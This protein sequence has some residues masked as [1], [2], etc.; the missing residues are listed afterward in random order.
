MTGGGGA[1]INAN[2]NTGP[3]SDI[4]L[5]DNLIKGNTA[6][7]DAA[8]LYITVYTASSIPGAEITLTRNEIA[9]NT[10]YRD[11]GGVYI[12]RSSSVNAIGDVTLNE[13]VI[14][15]N[16]CNDVGGGVYM[17]SYTNGSANLGTVNL[18]ENIVTGNSSYEMAGESI[19]IL[20]V[21]PE[22]P[23]LLT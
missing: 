10:G 11:G 5:I 19:S 23:T 17:Y 21:V 14:K 16:T 7:S 20:I 22:I 2:T 6:Y 9:A 15:D 3:A 1:H 18:I 12:R 4:Q 13:N 8:G